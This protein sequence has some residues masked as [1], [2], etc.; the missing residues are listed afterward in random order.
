MRASE[1]QYRAIFNASAD[2][3]VLWDKQYRRVDVN[4]AYMKMYGWAREEVIGKGYEDPRF[5]AEY[6][7]TRL[8][9]VRRALAGED[10]QAELEAIRSDGTLIRTEVH[11]IPFRHRGEPHVLAIARDIT[12]RKQS[13]EA[14]RASEEQYRAIFNASADAMLLRDDAM[15]IVD[16]NPA[17]LALCGLPREQ[18]VGKAHAPFVVETFEVAAERLL[19]DALVGVRGTLEAQTRSA[20]RHAAGRRGPGHAD[21]VPRPAARARRSP[22]TSRPTSGPKQSDSA[23]SRACDR[24]RRWRRSAS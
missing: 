16:A 13:E 19:K 10:C 7:N 1:E 20:R 9:L 12:E 23:S 6:A 15:T 14:L 4:P 3:L 17:F 8:E 22:E 11:A 24:R 2:A 21:A 5:P 18:V